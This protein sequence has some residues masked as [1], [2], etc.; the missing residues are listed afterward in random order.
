MKNIDVGSESDR[1]V[2]GGFG[3]PNPDAHAARFFTQYS[4]LSTFFNT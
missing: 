2:A 3:V 1:G 4:A